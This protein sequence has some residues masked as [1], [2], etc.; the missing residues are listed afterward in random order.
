[1]TSAEV[2]EKVREKFNKNSTNDSIVVDKGRVIIAVNEAQNKFTEWILEKKNEDDIRLIQH[3]L[4]D[5]TLVED[6]TTSDS[7]FFDLP[8]DYFDLSNL[9]AKAK[10]DSCT[11]DLLLWE[12]KTQNFNEL[13][14]DSNNEPSFY[15]RE[16]FYFIGGNKVRIFK[17][18]FEIKTPVLN[19]Y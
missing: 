4:K 9:T 12:V 18:D 8:P 13:L 15:Y 5:K 1:M 2:V 14:N 10:K 6:S 17:K 3:L 11:V 19:Y 16:T 7:I